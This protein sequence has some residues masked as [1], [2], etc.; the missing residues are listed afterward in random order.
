MYP[1]K[2][3]RG[4][5]LIELLVVIAIIA[6]LA[7]ILFPVFARAREA[8]RATSCRSNEKQLGTAIMMY[9][10]DYD[11]V[12]PSGNVAVIGGMGWAGQ[13]YPYVKNAG[14]YK[15][16]SDPTVSTA[17][18]VPVSYGINVN[19]GRQAE[20]M[21]S[22]PANTVLMFEVLGVGADVTQLFQPDLVSVAAN[23]G[24]GGGAGWIDWSVSS[25]K[26]DTG[27]MGSPPRTTATGRTNNVLSGRHN[28]MPNFLFADGH[29]KSAAPSRISPGTNNNNPLCP[30][31]TAGASCSGSTGA[32]AGTS[33]PN[34]T[35]T[36]STQ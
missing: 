7:A 34:F 2:R 19:V 36:F 29:V 32:A 12:Y 28:G 8:A 3:P 27:L 9:T 15:C 6:I 13:I 33:A 20:A 25:A 23:G 18:I 35:G 14:V 10:Q 16:A 17:P 26:Y 22:A 30:Q 5:T 4:F 11:E 31:D 1:S 21:L 24:D